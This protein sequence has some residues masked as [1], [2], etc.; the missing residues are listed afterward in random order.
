MTVITPNALKAAILRDIRNQSGKE[1]LIEYAERYSTMPQ[2][3]GPLKKQYHAMIELIKRYPGS[4]DFTDINEEWFG[5]F[6][7]WMESV[8]T[9]AMPSGYK[10]NY[11]SKV[12]RYVKEFCNQARRSGV[13]D[14]SGWI[15][16]QYRSQHEETESIYL[17]TNELTMIHHAELSASLRRAADRFLIG[18]FTGLRFSDFSQITPDSIRD[19][20]IYNR[21]KKT[22]TSVVIPM[23]PIVSEIFARY[24]GR[25]PRPITNQVFNRMLKE[26]GEA[27]GLIDPIQVTST[28]GGKKVTKTVKKCDMITTHTARRS[29]ASNAYLAGI[30][31]ISIMKITGH[32]TE[33]SFMKYIR[34]TQEQN[35][36]LIQSHPYFSTGQK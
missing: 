14:A 8:K 4:K 3:T 2:A 26:I 7:R 22:G 34:I 1:T 30:P 28:R 12:I 5:R 6:S 20:L 19:G 15:D 33:K 31:S 18:A 23:H 35:A 17:T 25:L 29:F 13:T 9:E 27:V 24:G 11:I 36:R 16:S 10:A 21:N 32:K